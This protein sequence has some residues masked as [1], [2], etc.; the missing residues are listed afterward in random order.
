M[1]IVGY[2]RVSTD[3]QAVSGLGLDVQ[4]AAIRATSERLGLPIAHISADEGVSGSKD[5]ADRE[6]FMEALSLLEKGDV[7][8][9]A[10]R[11]R[12]ARDTMIAGMIERLVARKK[13]RIVSAA[14]EG[15]DDDTP[16]GQLM[17]RIVDAF[18]EYERLIIAFRTRGALRAK[19]A[20]GDVAGNVP[21]GYGSVPTGDGRTTKRGRPARRLYPI[22]S[23]QSTLSFIRERRASG[24]SLRTI[25]ALLT[26]RG[27]MSRSGRRWHPDTVRGLLGAS[28]QTPTP[29]AP[30]DPNSVRRNAGGPTP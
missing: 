8:V 11:D 2:I 27:I 26:E 5:Q 21:Y 16:T 19:R 12:L 6:G 23:E 30:A 10:K 9:V 28:E 29:A 13:A 18:A 1:R 22:E 25:C 7:L 3:E 15:S 17:R 4:R 20:R 24:D 14:G